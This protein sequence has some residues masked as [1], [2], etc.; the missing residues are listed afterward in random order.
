MVLCN[1][2]STF[3]ITPLFR[4]IIHVKVVSASFPDSWR[5]STQFTHCDIF[6]IYHV[7]RKSLNDTKENI[8]MYIKEF[9]I[10]ERN[11][12]NNNLWRLDLRR[13]ASRARLSSNNF[14][15]SLRV[16]QNMN[17]ILKSWQYSRIMH[18]L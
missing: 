11:R 17:Q 2:I 7:P 12:Y 9:P 3:A 6:L 16:L 1:H 14:S 8:Y 10:C 4:M 5:Y 13:L 18:C 15:C